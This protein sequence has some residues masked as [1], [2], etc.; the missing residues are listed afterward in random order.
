MYVNTLRV[1]CCPGC[2]SRF[3]ELQLIFDAVRLR[4]TYVY[5]IDVVTYTQ[6]K[7]KHYKRDMVEQEVPQKCTEF[8]K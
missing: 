5:D 4:W 3:A 7:K 2:C 8:H 6:K 1:Q